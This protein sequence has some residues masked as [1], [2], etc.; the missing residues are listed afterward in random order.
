MMGSRTM[1][2]PGIGER[3]ERNRRRRYWTIIGALV[4]SGF[5]MGLGTSLIETS[6]PGGY[7]IG[8]IPPGWAIACVA[9]FLGAVG[10]GSWRYF[11]IVDEVDRDDNRWAGFFA[12][13]AL[14]VAY[15]VWYLLW[16]G[17]LVVEPIHETLFTG[18]WVT[19]CLAYLYRKFR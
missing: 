4:A 17:G 10:F 15:P 12:A 2:E 9:I 6:D 18:F 16:R 14:M 7:L 13:N 3:A 5:V 11:R 1:A 19:V 8:E